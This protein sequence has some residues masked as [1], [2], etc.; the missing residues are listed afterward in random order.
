MTEILQGL[1]IAFAIVL[2]AFL[3]IALEDRMRP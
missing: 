3:A 2:L 1:G